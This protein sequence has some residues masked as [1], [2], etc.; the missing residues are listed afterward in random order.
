MMFVCLPFSPL[1][2]RYRSVQVVAVLEKA[3]KI[4]AT[5][6]H[7]K[8]SCYKMSGLTDHGLLERMNSLLAYK[9]ANPT[10]N[11]P[12]Y[13]LL[14]GTDY[15][16]FVPQLKT[17]GASRLPAPAGAPPHLNDAELDELHKFLLR[18]QRLAD[19]AAQGG[20]P[21]LVDAEQSWFQKTIRFLT[22]AQMRRYNRSRPIIYNTYQHYLKETLPI[23][24]EDL[25]TAEKEKYFMGAKV[26]VT[27]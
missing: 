25:A 24:Q 7:A 19:A 20:V 11:L 21:L 16:T 13:S 12:W 6:P 15:T 8:Y 27:R 22:L 17:S 10:F 23:L 1:G 18:L 5:S 4:S 3:I 9:E 14:D 2:F 26:R